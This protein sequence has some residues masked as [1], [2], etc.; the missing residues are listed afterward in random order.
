MALFELLSVCLSDDDAPADSASPTVGR[1][2]SLTIVDTYEGRRLQYFSMGGAV[3][4][5]TGAFNVLLCLFSCQDANL[6]AVGPTASTT[7][8]K[9]GGNV[10]GASE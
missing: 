5:L 2:L 6:K 9:S 3:Y 1:L 4:G 7:V 8:G 10:V